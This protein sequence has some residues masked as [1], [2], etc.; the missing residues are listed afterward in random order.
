M[1][2]SGPREVLEEE[3]GFHSISIVPFNKQLMLTFTEIFDTASGTPKKIGYN[4]QEL[5]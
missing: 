4:F 2:S 3:T 5:Y 1:F